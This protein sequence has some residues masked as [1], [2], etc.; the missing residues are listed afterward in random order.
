MAEGLKSV[1]ISGITSVRVVRDL[2]IEALGDLETLAGITDFMSQQDAD[3]F[4]S[5]VAFLKRYY[6]RLE[7][8]A[9]MEGLG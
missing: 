8:L 7:V 9:R 6:E 3:T 1:D 4:K 2:L 5:N